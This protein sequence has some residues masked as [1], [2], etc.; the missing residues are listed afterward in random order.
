L[1]VSKTSDPEPLSN[2]YVANVS[3]KDFISPV[4][5]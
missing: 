4:G 5:N 2:I 1:N 3:D